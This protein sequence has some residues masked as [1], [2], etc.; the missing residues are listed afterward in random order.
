MAVNKNSI[1]NDHDSAFITCGKATL[2]AKWTPAVYKVTLNANGGTFGA[3]I[4]TIRVNGS[5]DAPYLIPE[6]AKGAS[7]VSPEG[8]TFL[9]W[10]TTPKAGGRQITDTDGK[11]LPDTIIKTAKSHELYARWG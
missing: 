5:Y 9:G 3:G 10:W 6:S 7:L 4:K 11:I 2:Y 1:V 8:K